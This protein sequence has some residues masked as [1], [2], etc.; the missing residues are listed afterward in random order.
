MFQAGAA[1]SVFCSASKPCFVLA[2]G[3]HLYRI[4]GRLALLRCLVMPC[5]LRS[6][7]V[8]AGV[9][10]PL[11]TAA[12][13]ATSTPSEQLP[14]TLT[15]T[16]TYEVHSTASGISLNEQLATI[17]TFALTSDDASSA[18]Y[19]A[20][21]GSHHWSASR[22]G[23]GDCSLAAD[24]TFDLQPGSGKIVIDK[25]RSNG[26]SFY[27]TWTSEPVDQPL[28]YTITCPEQGS[29]EVDLPPVPWWPAKLTGG[30]EPT[31]LNPW[32]TP[33]HATATGAVTNA[34]FFMGWTITP[35]L[36]KP[37]TSKASEITDVSTRNMANRRA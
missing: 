10:F 9:A 7:L 4:A 22:S 27:Y 37:C 12:Q 14:A 13:A 32:A 19:E 23:S 34:A 33:I 29:Q 6:L 15:G 1:S 24:S 36:K 3:R 26:S 28:P 16:V 30:P 31:H 20:Q 25:T 2:A 5:L 18:V 17:V 35:P 21:S 8:C 11:V